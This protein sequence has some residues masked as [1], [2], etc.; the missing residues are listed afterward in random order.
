MRR[1]ANTEFLRKLGP[2][3]QT[4]TSRIQS[5]ERLGGSV[6]GRTLPVGG[7]LQWHRSSEDFPSDSGG[8]Y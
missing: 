6:D 4:L 7:F 8:A 5:H 3:C 1:T 2:P